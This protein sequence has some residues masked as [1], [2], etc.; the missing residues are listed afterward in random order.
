MHARRFFTFATSIELNSLRPSPF[1]SRRLDAPAFPLVI[2]CLSTIEAK[3]IFGLQA[4]VERM[5]S[6]E[7][8]DAQTQE[9]QKA[10]WDYP[11]L[12]KE[13]IFYV[14]IEGAQRAIFR[15]EPCVFESFAT[16]NRLLQT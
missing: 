1:I 14:V 5:S 11:F 9:L 8:L 15:R 6:L 13:G 7:G 10:A 4:L 2:E 3:D 12:L 16:D